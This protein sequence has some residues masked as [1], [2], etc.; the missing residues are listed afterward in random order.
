VVRSFL[1]SAG[2]DKDDFVFF[3][4]SGL[5]GHDLVTPQATVKLLQYASAQPWFADWKASLPVGGVDGTL[6]GRFTQAP[7]KGHIFAKTGTLGE[8]RA[9]SGY[10][11][12]A[13]GQTVIFTIM[14][15]NHAPHSHADEAAMDRIVAAIAATN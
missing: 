9:L 10:L 12:C 4:G 14:V 13:S 1:E 15:D 6:A 11:D 8:A 2:I 3:D 5:S 7:L